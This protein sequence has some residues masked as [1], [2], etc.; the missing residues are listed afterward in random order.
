MKDFKDRSI[1]LELQV[2]LKLNKQ[3]LVMTGMRRVGKTTL[4]KYLYDRV[5][6]KNKIIL[7]LENV[8]VRKIFNEENYENVV[9]A[10]EQEGYDFSKKGYIFI[11]E[12]QFVRNSPSVIKYLYDKYKDVD[13]GIKFVVTGSSSFYLKNYF[14]ES[15]SG[16]KVIVNIYPLTYKEF[17]DFKG[18][19][20]QQFKSY[21]VKALKKIDLAQNK[22]GELYQEYMKYGGLPEVV[23]AKSIKEKRQLLE[24]VSKS[25]FQI[26]VTTLM[27]YKDVGVLRDLLILLTQRVGQKLNITN[28]ANVLKI[29]RDQVYAYLEFLEATFVIRLI[30]QKSSVDNKVSADDKLFFSDNG[31]AQMLDQISVGSLLENSVFMNL[32]YVNDLSYYQTNSGQ[33]IDFIVDNKIGL[34]VKRSPSQ[35]DVA[36]LKKRLKSAKLKRGYVVGLNFYDSQDVIMAWDL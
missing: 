9:L 24:D 27:D 17:L 19:K 23:L 32:A 15:L 8:L 3:V 7:D 30:S 21:K 2:N 11:D 28:L 14:S 18:I 33:E 25:Y 35:Q 31:L 5:K 1:L 13:K 4:L 34:E 26:D 29:R 36:N 12:I 6:T 10:L 22:F 20:K 16:R